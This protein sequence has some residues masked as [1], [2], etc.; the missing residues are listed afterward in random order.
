MSRPAAFKPWFTSDGRIVEDGPRH[1]VR[2]DI[3]PYRLWSIAGAPI[4]ESRAQERE[5]LKQHG[6]EAMSPSEVTMEKALYKPEP[7]PPI[8]EA[9][10]AAYDKVRSRT[11]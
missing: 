5:L 6:K 2:G 4:V 1:L 3:T 9:F 10:A 11:K 8:R 7:L